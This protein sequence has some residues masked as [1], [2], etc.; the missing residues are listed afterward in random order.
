MPR[1]AGDRNT[2]NLMVNIFD[3]R[4][5]PIAPRVDLLVRVLDGNQKKQREVSSRE[6]SLAFNKLPIFDNFGDNYTVLV[7]ARGYNGAG[8]TPVKISRNTW[9]NIDL[10]LLQKD[11]G[12]NFA[13]ASWDTLRDSHP[14]IFR[15]LSSGVSDAAARKRYDDMW[16]NQGATLAAFFN[17]TTAMKSIYLPTGTPLDY[18]QQLI[19]D[20]MDQTRFFAYADK[21]LIVQ[22]EQAAA[23]GLFVPEFGS[24]L[25]HPGATRSYKQ[26]QF[27]E[28][29]VQLTFHEGDTRRIGGVN[30]VKVEPDI[31]YYK[32]LAA[33]A[34]LEV[35]PNELTGSHTDPKQV[36]VLRWMAG[37]HA[38][39]PEFNPPYTIV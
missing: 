14:Q 38:G 2:G 15:L 18:C 8:F 24:G 19:W 17:I 3:G 23:Q 30:C 25:L 37:R 36:Y 22:V 7:S 27:G 35:I 20:E 10:M 32:D 29:N 34:L 12:F 31:D 9:Q 26:V 1:A 39:V 11:G 21:K 16:E 33:H 4:R 6:P 5:Q 13:Q 28:T